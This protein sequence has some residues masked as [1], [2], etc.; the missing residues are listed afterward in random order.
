MVLAPERQICLFRVSIFV[1][2]LATALA[3]PM[4]R[5]YDYAAEAELVDSIVPES[6]VPEEFTQTLNDLLTNPPTCKSTWDCTNACLKIEDAGTKKQ[7]QD[8]KITC[9]DLQCTNRQCG[10]TRVGCARVTQSGRRLLGAAACA[11]PL[12]TKDTRTTLKSVEKSISE[13]KKKCDDI[14]EFLGKRGTFEKEGWADFEYITVPYLPGNVVV[15]FK[16]KC[17]SRLQGWNY[18]RDMDNMLTKIQDAKDNKNLSEREANRIID[19][20]KTHLTGGPKSMKDVERM[21][22][23]DQQ[24]WGEVQKKEQAFRQ[25]ERMNME[26]LDIIRNSLRD[27]T[28]LHFRPTC[29]LSMESSDED[30]GQP[31]ESSDE[32]EGQQVPPDKLPQQANRRSANRLNAEKEEENAEEAEAAE[33]FVNKVKAIETRNQGPI[34]KRPTNN[35]MNRRKNKRNDQ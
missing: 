21:K 7:I 14:Q 4:G 1:L 15:G 13:G 9:G 2:V 24:K 3:A 6:P 27:S 25:V 8:L 28:D 26:D 35:L 16:P 32:D 17:I 19:Q 31:S 11:D 12:A 34:K 30:E 22:Q 18:C 29:Q 5:N 23:A 10:L 20:A 33:R